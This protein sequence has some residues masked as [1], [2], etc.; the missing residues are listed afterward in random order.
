M[1]LVYEALM[2]LSAAAVKHCCG[3]VYGDGSDAAIAVGRV[4]GMTLLCRTSCVA[5]ALPKNSRVRP[6]CVRS[7]RLD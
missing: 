6:I 1:F 4:R 7:V 5:I 3:L 2:Y